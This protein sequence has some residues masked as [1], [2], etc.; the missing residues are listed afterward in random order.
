M[1]YF[2]DT[3]SRFSAIIQSKKINVSTNFSAEHY[4]RNRWV[5]V[6]IVINNLNAL[7][8]SNKTETYYRIERNWSIIEC[9]SD[10]GMGIAAEDIDKIFN[11]F[12]RSQSNSHPEIK[13]TGLG[14]NCKRLCTLLNIEIATVKKTK[15]LLLF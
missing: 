7:K 6:L 4:I 14:F 1:P 3:I 2:L 11:Q 12:Y 10:T 5:F 8:Y 13:G 15:E 9:I